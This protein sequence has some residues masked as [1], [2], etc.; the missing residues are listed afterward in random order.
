MQVI[1]RNSALYAVRSVVP[2]AGAW[3]LGLLLLAGLEPMND[4]LF[5]LC[6]VSWVWEGGCPGCGLGHSIAYL[7]RGE[8]GPS[9]QAHPL[10][11]PALLLLSWRVTELLAQSRKLYLH[12]SKL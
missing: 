1:N 6:P 9:W 3:I 8:L 4:H 10:G 12:H 2:E 11:V 7:F 5:S